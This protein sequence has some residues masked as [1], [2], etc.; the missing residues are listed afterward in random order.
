MK[1]LRAHVRRRAEHVRLDESSSGN[2]VQVSAWFK[3]LA[4]R[5]IWKVSMKNA[6]LVFVLK[7]ECGATRQIACFAVDRPRVAFQRSEHDLVFWQCPGFGLC[8]V[9]NRIDVGDEE[10]SECRCTTI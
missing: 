10:G 8:E 5:V 9:L 2:V 4:L 3:V 7:Q 6:V 1:M